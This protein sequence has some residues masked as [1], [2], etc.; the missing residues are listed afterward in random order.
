MADD[1]K[2]QGIEF[3]IKGSAEAASHSLDALTYSLRLLN[4][5]S[6]E[7][8]GLKNISRALKDINTA[9][10]NTDI[11]GLQRLSKTLNSLGTIESKLGKIFDGLVQ[12]SMIDFSGFKY[13]E[14]MT[15]AFKNFNGANA[16]KFAKAIDRIGASY[17]K[18]ENIFDSLMRI[19]MIDF[20]NLKQAQEAIR[21]IVSTKGTSFRIGVAGNNGRT[22]AADGGVQNTEAETIFPDAKDINEKADA[23]SNLSGQMK[24]AASAFSTFKSSVGMATKALEPLM[25]ALKWFLK[26]QWD[27]FKT[28]FNGMK[29]A[30]G[31]ALN[32][33][34]QFG[35]AALN[36]ASAMARLSLSTAAAPFR[37]LGNAIESAAKSFDKLLSSFARIAFYRFIRSFIKEISD[38]FK[39]GVE[40]IYQW[41]KAIDGS[42]SQSMDSLASHLLYLKNSI[43]AAVAPLLELLIPAFEKFIGVVVQALNVVAQFFSFLGGKTTWTKAVYVQTEWAEAV[44]DAEEAEEDLGETIEDAG[45][46]AGT[47]LDGATDALSDFKDEAADIQKYLAPFD[48]LNVLPALND[49]NDKSGS[50][51]DKSGKDKTGKDKSG[52]DNGGADD[53]AGKG[54]L[55]PRMMF[56]EVPIDNALADLFQQIKDLI[57]AG[58]WKGLGELIGNKINEMIDSIPWEE[59]GHKIGY[60]AN[61]IIQTLYYT[62]KTI[63]FRGLGTHLADAFTAMLEE[64]D[65]NI[66]GRLLVRRFTLIFDTL[67]GFIDGLSQKTDLIQQKVRDFLDGIIDEIQEWIAEHNWPEEGRKLGDSISAL[68]MGA[69]ESLSSHEFGTV[70]TALAEYLNGVFAEIPWEETARTLIKYLLII[71]ENIVSF[72]ED[73]DWDQ[74]GSAFATFI[75]GLVDEIGD[76]ITGHDWG[77]IAIRMTNGLN[78]MIHETKW[79]KLGET[80]GDLVQNFFAFI[81]KGLAN[82]DWVAIGRNLGNL[83]N[84]MAGEVNFHDAGAT[85]ADLLTSMFDGLFA[86]LDTLDWDQFASDIADFIN[87]AIEKLSEW[88]EQDKDWSNIARAFTTGFNTL[89]E[90]VDWG[91]VGRVLSDAI[92]GF[93]DFILEGL[94]NINWDEV[95]EAIRDFFS[96]LNLTEILGKLEEIAN[97]LI[98]HLIR[99]LLD[100]LGAAGQK[101][102]NDG[103]WV[104]ALEVLFTTLFGPAAGMVLNIFRTMFPELEAAF[105]SAGQKFG[106]AF[107]NEAISSF[108]SKRPDLMNAFESAANDA[109]DKYNSTLEKQFGNA[110]RIANAHANNLRNSF[111]NTMSSISSDVESFTT[112][113]NANLSK[114]R[115]WAGVKGYATGGFPNEGQLFMA[116]EAGPEMVGRIGHHTAVANNDQIVEAVSI[117]VETANDGVIA[118]IMSGTAQVV[119]AIQAGSGDGGIDWDAVASGLGR[120]QTRQLRAEGRA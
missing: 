1:V 8:S 79:D 40:N 88:M 19:S 102:M 46:G 31:G 91:E 12:I 68:V 63:D 18:L 54:G 112:R 20:S 62:L 78:T 17:N 70:G 93:L 50:G 105:Q 107:N 43:G 52:K 92:E 75:N 5:Q 29:T 44:W 53:D 6:G 14:G 84:S 21:A 38:G 32:I 116:R 26:F 2:M 73:F 95:S 111:K 100:A 56:E 24:N 11:S 87:G 82:I 103:A 115:A 120:I 45:D 25:E 39:T 47:A 108:T 89:I 109:G 71:P 51:K 33:V 104:K 65:T 59:I 27:I 98:T 74:A 114:L 41:S 99:G 64:I 119:G 110:E 66:L 36:A 37:A 57:D 90:K 77:D 9:S 30:V 35:S 101:A 7:R 94:N 67:L 55:D 117:G 80:L 97:E 23:V 81:V 34:R 4:E 113:A 15:E 96:N 118:A 83:F 49:A 10:K 85:L 22:N 60:I 86:L 69:F 28:G 106:E 48:E 58:D 76:F 13:L 16:E 3:E 72:L 61:G 42:F